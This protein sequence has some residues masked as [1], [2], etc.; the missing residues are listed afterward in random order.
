MGMRKEGRT[1]MG[2]SATDEFITRML[3]EQMLGARAAQGKS[4]V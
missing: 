2:M 3:R 4:V 1:A